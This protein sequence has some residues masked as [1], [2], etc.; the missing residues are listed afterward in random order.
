MEVAVIE[1]AEAVDAIAVGATIGV[2]IVVA[3]W[4]WEIVGDWW[5]RR[6]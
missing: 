2:A 5:P 4:V 1:T 6:R 3:L